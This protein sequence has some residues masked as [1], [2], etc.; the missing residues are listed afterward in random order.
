[1]QPS[2]LPRIAQLRRGFLIATAVL[3]LLGLIAAV[4]GLQTAWIV[5]ANAAAIATAVAAWL[6]REEASNQ[7]ELIA[8]VSHE[9]RTPLTGILGTL[10]LLTDSTIPLEPSEVDELLIAAHSDANHLLHVVGNLHAR[11]R[12]DRAVLTPD[13]VPTNLR[14]IIG[15]A[16]SRSPQV[17]NRCY[18]S[19]GDQAV[20]VG[21]PQLLM[22]IVNNLVQNI[23]RY[24][25]EGEVRINFAR[26]GEFMSASFHDSGPGIP[27]H[28]AERIFDTSG[29]TEGLGLGLTLSRQ[30]AT[31]MGGDLSLDN[32]GQPGATFTLRLPA[33]DEIVPIDPGEEIIP[34]DRSQ[35]HS[36]RARLLVN[37]AEALAR[38][39]L[40]QVVGGINKI[41]R[42]LLG[43]TGAVLFVPG[44]D[45]SFSAAGPYSD[46]REIAAANSRDLEEVMT[47][48]QTIR[49]DDVA[50]SSWGT[51]E[52]LGGHAAMLLPVHENDEI[53]AV[54]AVGWKSTDLMP[55]GN[56]VDVA[57]ALAEITASAI[58]RAALSKDVVY[59]RQLRSSVLDELPI[60]VSVFAG[61]PP[62]LVDWNLKERELLG[63]ADPGIRPTDL[64]ES[65]D[66]FNVRFADGTPL[67]VDNAPVTQAIRTGKA[68]G[69]FILLVRRIDGSQTHTRT[70][71]APFFDSQGK[72]AGAVVTSEPMDLALS[73]SFEDRI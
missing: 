69:P 21:D 44:R 18:L 17:A 49:I 20:V 1:M 31:A 8:E 34:G 14:S 50:N 63:I 33:S 67:T 36:P 29:S 48:G 42:E 12:L 9:L 35:A 51:V 15:K 65:Q 64:G 54:L 53:V 10:E 61:E 46:E 2:S 68:T 58:A 30:L 57:E 7:T 47:K 40:D 25:P 45:G 22:Q 26:T 28:R 11:S 39:S 73:P 41:Y 60:A 43:S 27:A 4:S 13:V 23:E 59:E 16:V 38:G 56:A 37:L 62:R 52:T 55:S 24:A 19:P 3:A 71:C 32:P 70:Y 66:L 6:V 72:V 5:A